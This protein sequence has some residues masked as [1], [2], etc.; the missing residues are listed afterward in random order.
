M[1]LHTEQVLQQREAYVSVTLTVIVV[2]FNAGRHIV[3]CATSLVGQCH[4]LIVIDNA[5][6]DDSLFLL[7]QSK[8]LLTT[9]I[10]RNTHNMGFAAACNLGAERASGDLILFLNPDCVVAPGTLALLSAALTADASAGMAGG[11]LLNTDGS[12]QAGGRRL[13][14]TPWRSLVRAFGLQRFKTRYPRLFEGYDL[15]A[16]PL[17]NGTAPV[18]AISGAC[19]LVRRDALISVGPL[20]E[21]YF[22]HCEDLDWCMR[23]WQKGWRVLFVPNAPIT[24]LKGVCSRRRPILVE[25]YKH[26]GMV[27]FYR[28]FFRHQYPGVLMWLVISAVWLRFVILTVALLAKRVL[29]S[30]LN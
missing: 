8:L 5:S 16:H 22:M 21:G 6:S 17:P 7:E 29:H 3:D 13:V 10:V 19:M 30:A 24:H 15:H 27:R 20:D 2:N 12:E 18:E 14:P 23:F 11:L 26:K 1:K 28:K 9:A 25:C 4:E